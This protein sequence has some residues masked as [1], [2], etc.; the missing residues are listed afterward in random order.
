[1]EDALH[2]KKATLRRQNLHIK[3]VI[4]RRNK[5]NQSLEN[6]ACSS[7]KGNKKPARMSAQFNLETKLIFPM[8]SCA[9]K[10]KISE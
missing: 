6:T 8:P 2:C 4:E 5:F 9:W 7:S 10:G 1:M 3:G